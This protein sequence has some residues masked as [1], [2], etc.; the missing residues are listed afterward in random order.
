MSEKRAPFVPPQVATLLKSGNKI[1][2]IK[3]LIDSNPGLGLRDAKEAVENHER[4]LHSGAPA[5]P[6]AATAFASAPVAS[7]GF[8][9]AARTAISNG[10]TIVAI[11]IVREAYGL[12]L[13]EAK[14][15]VEAYGKKGEAALKGLQPRGGV[16]DLPG[17]VVA[18]I[19][20][21]HRDRAAQLLHGKFGLSAQDAL[22]RVA[23]YSG[24]RHKS[25]A[26]GDSGRTVSPG[27]SGG[28]AWWAVLAVAAL[29]AVAVYLV[30]G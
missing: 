16:I 23:D 4:L 2:A 8:P 7:G 5:G 11:K 14:D 18:L 30:I 24:A 17:E 25:G 29:L 9:A 10:Q 12:G 1:Q 13:S 28:G 27:D 22:S 6:V 3:L 20:G 19:Q 26:V 21:G 15:L